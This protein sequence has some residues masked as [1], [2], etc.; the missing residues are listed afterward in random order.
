LAS[1]GVSVLPVGG[2][3]PLQPPEAAQLLVLAVFHCRVTDEPAGTE[4]SLAF[5][6]TVGAAAVAVTV[7]AGVA[8]AELPVSEPDVCALELKPQA[9]SEPRAAN[10][11]IDCNANAN[12]ERWLRRIELITRLPIY[13]VHGEKFSAQVNPFI[14]QSSGRHSLSIFQILQP[15]AIC[16]LHMSIARISSFAF[17]KFENRTADT[18]CVIDNTGKT[19]ED[20]IGEK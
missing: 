17:S 4:A 2:M 7:A 6:V 5:K 18:S 11:S 1:E 10:A 9:A 8:E 20:V 19:R 3:L 16:K 15:V 12:R 13:V 14:S